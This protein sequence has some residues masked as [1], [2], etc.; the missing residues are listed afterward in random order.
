MQKIQIS[1]TQA[2]NGTRTRYLQQVAELYQLWEISRQQ[3]VL[4]ILVPTL[5][6]QVT[7]L[8]SVAK[9]RGQ[10]GQTGQNYN[11]KRANSNNSSIINR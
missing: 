1:Y 6:Q 9:T 3:E 2:Q 7:M 10:I 11:I 4:E 8:H 5:N